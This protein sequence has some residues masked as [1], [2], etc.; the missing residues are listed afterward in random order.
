[1]LRTAKGGGTAGV[2]RAEASIHGESGDM[3]AVSAPSHS[4]ADGMNL[5]INDLIT[6]Q[7]TPVAAGQLT[8]HQSLVI[9]ATH[10]RGL[11]PVKPCSA[12]FAAESALDPQ[13]IA[14]WEPFRGAVKKDFGFQITVR[15]ADDS[16][17]PAS[18]PATMTLTRIRKK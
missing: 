17:N 1:V 13:W 16:G 7:T 10:S 4:I 3:L 8:I 14:Y 5:S 12:E 6:C 11:C 15:V 9:S 18:P 2:C